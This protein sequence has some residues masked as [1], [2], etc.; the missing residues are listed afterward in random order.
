MA[1]IY[2]DPSAP[3]NNYPG[4][5]QLKTV[6]IT[7]RTNK[8]KY[9]G[10]QVDFSSYKNKTLTDFI[11]LPIASLTQS[12]VTARKYGSNGESEEHLNFK[13]LIARD[14]SLIGIKN[15]CSVENDS[16]IFP[17]ADRPDIVFTCGD[18]RFFIVEIEIENCLPGA[19]QA[20]KYKSLFCAEKG[21]QLNADNVI[22]MLVARKINSTVQQ[23]C[24]KYGV[25][26]IEMPQSGGQ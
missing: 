5:E 6:D 24:N 26:T 2:N 15:I 20:I 19:Y 1:K 13:N 12:E 8:V 10:K 22:T 23:F 4:Q 7:L 17:S 16:H 21:F 9:G 18:N 3:F 25:K 11:I 14:G